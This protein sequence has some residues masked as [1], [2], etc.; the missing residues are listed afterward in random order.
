MT[1]DESVPDWL[2][3]GRPHIW[4]PYTQMQTAQMPPA[5]IATDGARI[6]L[7]DGRSLIG[8][9]ASWWAACHG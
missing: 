4:L 3:A 7:A 8:G 2:R 5:A 9:M 1:S 6:H